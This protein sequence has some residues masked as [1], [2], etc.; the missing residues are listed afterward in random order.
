M[1]SARNFLWTLASIWDHDA[2]CLLHEDPKQFDCRVAP[3][4]ALYGW[5]GSQGRCTWRTPGCSGV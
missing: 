3:S 1:K 2:E 4:G 5:P